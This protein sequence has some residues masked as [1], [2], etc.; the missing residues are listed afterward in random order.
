MQITPRFRLPVILILA[1]LAGG[2]R[3]QPTSDSGIKSANL[4]STRP[5]YQWGSI[6]LGGQPSEAD[7]KIIGDLGVRTVIDLRMPGEINWNEAAVVQQDGMR[8]VALPFRTPEQLT[9]ELL[10][11]ALAE[12]RDQ[13]ARPLLL[14]CA[15]NNRCGAVWYAY[16]RLDGGLSPDAALAEAKT[17]GLRTITYLDPVRAYVATRLEVNDDTPAN[18]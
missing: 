4:G 6:Y 18:P 3:P 10:D 2:C 15:S 8:Y 16:R 17:V 13:S 11:Q 7:F 9:P 1:G 14:H 5:A 12:L